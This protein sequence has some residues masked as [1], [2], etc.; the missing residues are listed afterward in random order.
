MVEGLKGYLE[1][2]KSCGIEEVPMWQLPDIH[3]QAKAAPQAS[4]APLPSAPPFT[5]GT[6]REPAKPISRKP[7]LITPVTPEELFPVGKAMTLGEVQEEIGDCKRCKLHNGR[8]NIVFGAGNPKADL[9]FVG[10]GPGAE[11]DQ[12]GEPFV[13]KAGQLLANIIERGMKLKREEVY[14]C[15][16]VKCGPPGNRDPEKDEINICSPFLFKQLRAI[17]PRIIVALGRAAASTLLGRNVLITAERGTWSEFEGARVMLTYH[18][19]F[20]LERY[21]EEVRRQVYNDMLMVVAELK[22]IKRTKDI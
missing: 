12:Q 7:V 1:Y 10:D 6:V 14:V 15:N 2:M 16:V 22:N 4:S 19:S 5:T 20:V 21:T 3:V 18:P 17:K 11:E 9:I 8:T 13:G